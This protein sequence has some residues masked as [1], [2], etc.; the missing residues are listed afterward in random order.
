[1]E[2]AAFPTLAEK[3]GAFVRLF[4]KMERLIGRENSLRV[5]TRRQLYVR[6]R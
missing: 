3:R 6:R 1:M 2:E 5:L 4:G